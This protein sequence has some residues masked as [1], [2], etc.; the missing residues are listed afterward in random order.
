[1]AAEQQQQ[2]LSPFTPARPPQHIVSALTTSGLVSESPGAESSF[3]GSAPFESPRLDVPSQSPAE[4]LEAVK[5]YLRDRSDQPLH[6]VEYVGLVSLLKDSVQ[7]PA[8]RYSLHSMADGLS[9]TKILSLFGSPPALRRAVAL[10]QLLTPA[11]LLP[12]NKLPVEHCREIPM[13]STNG[14][15]L[16]APAHATD[17]KAQRSGQPGQHPQN[18]SFPSQIRHLVKRMPRGDVWIRSTNPPHLMVAASPHPQ[19]RH[20]SNLTPSLLPFP[21]RVAP[22]R[23]IPP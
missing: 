18:S 4:K 20:V 10:P 16:G 15:V 12:H 7:G 23:L 19:P 17:I 13:A 2:P 8:L 9:Q 21:L 3:K 5:Q 11:L 14:R 1:M 6:H 22:H